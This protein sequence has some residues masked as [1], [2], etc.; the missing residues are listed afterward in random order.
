M[1]E[2]GRR[3]GRIISDGKGTEKGENNRGDQTV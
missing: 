3:R 1:M 2:R